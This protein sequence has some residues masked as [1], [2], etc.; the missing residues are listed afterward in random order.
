MSNKLEP[1]GSRD[2]DGWYEWGG[3]DAYRPA[4]AVDLIQRNGAYV[5]LVNAGAVSWKHKGLATDVIKWRQA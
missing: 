2:A 3:G 5:P 1:F 4:G